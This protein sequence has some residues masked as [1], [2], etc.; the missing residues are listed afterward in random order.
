MDKEFSNY[1]STLTLPKRRLSS[2]TSLRKSLATPI[3]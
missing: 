3:S 1:S 2:K